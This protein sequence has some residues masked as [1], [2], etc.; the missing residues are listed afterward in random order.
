LRVKSCFAR[1]RSPRCR[2]VTA[3]ICVLTFITKLYP[4]VAARFYFLY[5]APLRG[6]LVNAVPAPDFTCHLPPRS[7]S[8]AHP[9]LSTASRPQWQKNGFFVRAFTALL[10]VLRFAFTRSTYTL[11]TVTLH[12]A[13]FPHPVAHAAC[14]VCIVTPD[15]RTGSHYCIGVLF[16]ITAAF[17]A[18]AGTYWFR[19]RQVL[20]DGPLHLPARMPGRMLRFVLAG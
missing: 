16:P 17:A 15:Y 2:F 3:R 13:T 6:F 7:D 10:H 14:Y 9:S 19:G 1:L 18:P 11:R 20:R 4:Y 8:I 5:R 12:A